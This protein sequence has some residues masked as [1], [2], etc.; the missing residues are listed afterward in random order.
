[1]EKERKKKRKK[2]EK[3]KRIISFHEISSG[4]WNARKPNGWCK[5][6]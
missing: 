2:K 6:L 1:M 5:E 3:E 4:Y